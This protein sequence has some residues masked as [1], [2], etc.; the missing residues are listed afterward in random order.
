MTALSDP[1]LEAFCQNLALGLDIHVAHEKAGYAKDL[2]R[3]NS[4]KMAKRQVVVA[5]LA[6]IRGEMETQRKLARGEVGDM[7]ARSLV[8]HAIGLGLAQG[9]PQVL[10]SIAKFLDDGTLG[11]AASQKPLTIG[12]MLAL[13]KEIDPS[14]MLWFVVA[15]LLMLIDGETGKPLPAWTDAGGKPRPPYLLPTGELVEA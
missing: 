9:D 2:S 10:A 12:E 4:A 15:D 6:E 3:S 13:A 7:T 1:R 5:R 11:L 14:M 8:N